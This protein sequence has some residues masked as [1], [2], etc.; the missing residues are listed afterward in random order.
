VR[1]AVNNLAGVP[2]IV[3]GV[4]GLGFFCYIVGLRSTRCFFRVEAAQP[5][6]RHGRD[7][8]GVV[9]AGA[10]D[11]AGGDRR[12]GGGAGGRAR[13]D[14]RG[15]V[16]LRREQVADDP[17]D[18][19]AARDAGHHDGG[20]SGDGARRGRGR[21]AD[22]GGRGQAGARTAAGQVVALRAPERSFMHLG[23]H[24]FDLGFQSQNSEAA[25]P[26]VFTTTLLL[27]AIIAAAERS[28]PIW[29]RSRLRGC[30]VTQF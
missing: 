6:L 27:I 9:D 30:G 3:F 11:A 20:D 28:P 26:M 23:F 17:A 10:A 13:L 4:F 25:K 21:A 1:I 2:S 7:P 29:L 12:D 19:A 22:A 15:L 14:A 5:D 16:R 18:R 8:V 24:I